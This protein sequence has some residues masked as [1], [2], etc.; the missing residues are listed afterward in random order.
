MTVPQLNLN[1]QLA[2]VLNLSINAP[3]GHNAQPWAFKK[4]N[5]TLQ[6]WNV[7]DKDKIVFN[8]RGRGN[9]IGLGAVIENILIVSSHFGLGSII[10]VFPRADEK[11]LVAEITFET[12]GS[13]YC[14]QDLYP[15]VLNRATNRRNYAAKP[16]TKEDSD[17]LQ[18][19]LDRVESS[20]F[21]IILKGR[22][23]VSEVA[24]YLSCADRLV[25]DNEQV[26][27]NL[28]DHVNWTKEEEERKREGLYV[29]TKELSFANRFLFRRVFSKWTIVGALRR[30]GLPRIAAGKRSAVYSSASCIG[31]ITGPNDTDITFLEAG[32]VLQ[33]FWLSVT[34]LGLSFQPVAIGLLYLGQAIDRG[35]C[36]SLSRTETEYIENAYHNIKQLYN[37]SERTPVFA[38]KIGYSDPPSAVSLKRAVAELDG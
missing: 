7:P 4:R 32:R 33:R 12:K 28:F 23:K 18:R 9:K 6:V 25:F 3:S 1:H 29:G 37:V 17:R 31:L 22:D 5:N 36:T 24:E 16:L 10:D 15:F 13:E 20:G 35:E 38:F 2:E 19:V 8:Y 34:A 30:L 21:K 27:G 14:F 26:H 11:N